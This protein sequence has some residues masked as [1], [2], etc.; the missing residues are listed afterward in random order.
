MERGREEQD[1][2]PGPAAALSWGQSPRSCVMGQGLQT[3]PFAPAP[4]TAGGFGTGRGFVCF[5]SHL[6]GPLPI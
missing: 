3:T 6:A 4:S 2:E 5:P 1:P